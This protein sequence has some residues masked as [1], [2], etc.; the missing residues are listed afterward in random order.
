MKDTRCCWYRENE[1]TDWKTGKFHQWSVNY[2]E[3][4]PTPVAIV[5]DEKT[6]SV[7]VVPAYCINFGCAKP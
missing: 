1:K 4:G 2:H 5:E 6:Y 7:I 3:H